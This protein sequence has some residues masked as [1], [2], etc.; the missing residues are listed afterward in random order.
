L[1]LAL[2]AFMSAS[3]QPAQAQTPVPGLVFERDVVVAASDGLPLRANVFRPAQPGR[4]P[5][6]LSMSP[7]G[8]DIHFQ[9]YLPSGWAELIRQIPDVCRGST[10]QFMNWETVDPERWV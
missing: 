5:V 10:C 2:L 9:D 7:Y 3:G 4:Y 8:K 6:I 1:A